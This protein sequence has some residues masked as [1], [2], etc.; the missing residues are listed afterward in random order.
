MTDEEIA[1]VLRLWQSGEIDGFEARE[2]TGAGSAG[3]LAALGR[4]HSS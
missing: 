4:Q 3:W 1:E 2:R